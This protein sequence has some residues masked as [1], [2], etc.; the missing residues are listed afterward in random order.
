[1]P[2]SRARVIIDIVAEQILSDALAAGVIP[3]SFR[4]ALDFSSGTSDGSIDLV[5]GKSESG[6]AASTTTSYD[7]SGSLE[8]RLGQAVVFAEV[9]LIAIR[10][11]RTTALAWVQI[12][13]HATAGFGAVAS[14][15]GFWGAA[16][17]SGGGNYVGPAL[18]TGQNGW[19][20][21]HDPTGVPVTA[22]TADI[23][24][25]ITSGVS[26]PTNAYD[27]LILGRSA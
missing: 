12:G 16:L 13:P 9:C 24:A 26:G 10:N 27:L 21:F 5:Y 23:L 18:T 20:V 7:L 2:T 14:N 8:N 6:I 1:M 11:K 3:E 4:E 19:A 22:T 15:K 25:T 17:G